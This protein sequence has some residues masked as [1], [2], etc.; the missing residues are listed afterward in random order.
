MMW[1]RIASDYTRRALQQLLHQH[2]RGDFPLVKIT[3]MIPLVGWAYRRMTLSFTS[4]EISGI[5][6]DMAGRSV[7]ALMCAPRFILRLQVWLVTTVLL[8][9]VVV[10]S[11]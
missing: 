1:D 8:I 7:L 10:M 5:E 2:L 11:L 6:I 9:A 3:L 4:L